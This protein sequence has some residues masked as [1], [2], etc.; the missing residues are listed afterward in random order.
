MGA[1]AL[2]PVL[3]CTT[4]VGT[5]ATAARGSVNAN[6]TMHSIKTYSSNDS[7]EVYA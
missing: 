5:A 2:A 4:G 1:G 3:R 6:T 7:D